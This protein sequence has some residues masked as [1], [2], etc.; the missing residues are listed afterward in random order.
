[1]VRPCLQPRRKAPV[2]I[3]GNDNWII[4]FE[5][6][7]NKL[8]PSDTIKLAPTPYPKSK[9]CATGIA[10]NKSNTLLYT[11]TK[12]DNSLYVIDLVTRVIKSKVKLDAEAYSCVLS[13]DEKTLYISVWNGGEVALYNTVT[14]S[15]ST[16]KV[17]SHPN[18]LLLNKK[19]TRLFVANANDNSVSIINTATAK[20]TEI[21]STSLFPTKL[22]GST[23]NGLA[24]SANEKTLYIANADN[25]CL[26]VFDVS[27]PG[28]SQSRGFIPV[29]WYPT[30]VKV[31]GKK[32]LVSNGKGFTSM[33]NPQG[34]MP[35][36]K[37]R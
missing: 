28:S 4:D 37:G 32:I 12:E 34:P 17:G 1:M 24:L 22:T 26:A 13:P 29:G 2:C 15:L 5:I 3:G 19:G 16:I 30:N 8:I 33:A 23:T 20:V 14:G 6:R 25:N 27:I 9:V 7:N 21:V 35:V 11:T 10:V 36:K 31:L 18:E